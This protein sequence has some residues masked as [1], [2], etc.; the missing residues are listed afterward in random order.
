[1]VPSATEF[2]EIQVARTRFLR[3]IQLKI[4]RICRQARPFSPRRQ[5]RPW[6]CLSRRSRPVA[7]RIASA[8]FAASSTGF[9][10]RAT[11]EVVLAIVER[12]FCVTGVQRSVAS[13]SAFRE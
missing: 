5:F 6:L 13:V 9:N 1:M 4:S 8:R 3:R 10:Q 12:R 7:A 2:V 11:I